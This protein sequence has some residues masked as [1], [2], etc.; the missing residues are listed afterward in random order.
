MQQQIAAILVRAP[1]L[2]ID[3]PAFQ[4]RLIGVRAAR[5]SI[6]LLV[7]KDRPVAAL[8]ITTR[9]ND[10]LLMLGRGSAAEVEVRSLH[11]SSE[12]H[13]AALETMARRL[14]AAITAEQRDRAFELARQ[15]RT[16]PVG[17]PLEHYRQLVQGVSAQGL[18]RVGFGCNQDCGI[19]WQDRDWGRFPPEQV[20][21]WI[22]DL[23]RLGARKLLISGG[24][25]TLDRSLEHYIRRAKELGFEDISLETNAIQFARPGFAERLKDAGLSFA[26]ISLHSG[27]PEVSDRITRAPGTHTRT[28]QGIHRL[29]EAKIPTKFNAVMTAEGLDHLPAL[30]DFL[31]REFAH[32]QA[33]LL[34]MLSSPVDPYDHALF[35]EILPEPERLRRALRLALDRCFEL[36]I[37]VS[38]LDGP[39]GPP[40]CA[41]GADPRVTHLELV[42]EPLTS[43]RYLPACEGCSVRQ[44]CFGIGTRD[45]ALFG[46]RCA[47]PVQ[48]GEPR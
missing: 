5:Q 2:P 4:M 36:G 24:E 14:R 34:L 23:W 27:D 3:L 47:A 32:H 28:I 35:D 45:V 25:P 41:H 8:R 20:L 6:E 38:G 43:R 21:C 19:C 10:G 9:K 30:P 26:F 48:P 17:V 29:M 18:V 22:E 39:C 40:L 13:H 12:Q 11:G 31:H 15:L 1:T 16:L 44:A 37:R 7:G 33:E 46:E 42:R